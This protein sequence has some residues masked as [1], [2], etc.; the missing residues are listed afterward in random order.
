MIIRYKKKHTAVIKNKEIPPVMPKSRKNKS[1]KTKT[2]NYKRN[3][4]KVKQERHEVQARKEIEEKMDNFL[5]K[6]GVAPNGIE[7]DVNMKF[8]KKIGQFFKYYKDNVILKV[9][10][11]GFMTPQQALKYCKKYETGGLCIAKD[12]RTGK[13]Y[14]FNPDMYDEFFEKIK[15]MVRI[16]CEYKEKL[17]SDTLNFMLHDL[18][19]RPPKANGEIN[20]LSVG[21]LGSIFLDW[22]YKGAELRW[23][24]YNRNEEGNGTKDFS[25]KFDPICQVMDEEERMEGMSQNA[26]YSYETSDGEIKTTD[27]HEEALEKGV[28]GMIATTR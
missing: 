16:K 17:G 5:K 26:V 9:A 10:T 23:C 14:L 2:T 20:N 25:G 7:S 6:S 12:E 4:E 24:W 22:E 15:S 3:V 11:K 18:L 19:F 1:K 8:A 28:G 21:F 13:E 27:N